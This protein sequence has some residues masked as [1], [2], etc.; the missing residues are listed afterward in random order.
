MATYEINIPESKMSDVETA[1]K[2]LSRIPVDARG[3][4]LFTDSEWV[5]ESLRR[6]VRDTDVR[7]RE[8]AA[9]E[10]VARTPDDS[11]ATV[12]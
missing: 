9:R 5:G 11:I 7:Y 1:F 3:D 4:P 10:L 8:L 2:S 6:Y 12:A